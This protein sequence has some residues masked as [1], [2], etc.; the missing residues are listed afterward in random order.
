[1]KKIEINEKSVE[2]A[3]A[4]AKVKRIHAVSDLC[5][6]INILCMDKK[7]KKELANSLGIDADVMAELIWHLNVFTINELKKIKNELCE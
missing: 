4:I 6:L 2:Q 1:M 5:E 7:R 3:K